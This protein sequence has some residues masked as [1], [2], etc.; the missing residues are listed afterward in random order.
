MLRRVMVGLSGIVLALW[1]VGVASAQEPGGN[2]PGSPLDPGQ[3][4]ELQRPLRGGARFDGRLCRETRS[5]PSSSSFAGEYTVQGVFVAAGDVTGDGVADVVNVQAQITVD[6]ADPSGNTYV[7]HSLRGRVELQNEAGSFSLP[8][9]IVIDAGSG[10]DILR[11]FA[12]RTMG[13]LIALLLP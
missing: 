2:R 12:D 7:G 1:A 3:C 5:V 6:P 9:N 10:N 13:V 11:A 4:R 8:S